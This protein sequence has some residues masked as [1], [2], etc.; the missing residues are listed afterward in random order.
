MR[1]S[2]ELANAME[3]AYARAGYVL[4]RV[5]VPEQ[6]LN[7]D[8]PL[9]SS[10]STA[11]SKKSRSTM[12]RNRYGHWSPRGMSWLIGRKRIKLT[13][14]EQHL[15]ISGD[16]PGLRLKSTL[17]RGKTTGGVLLVLEGTHQVV[18]ATATID[19]R[20]PVSLGTWTYGTTVAINSAF[21]FGEQFYG[22]A[23]AGGDPGRPS[24]PLRRC[25]CSVPAW[26]CPSAS[27]AGPSIRNTPIRAL[28]QSR[29][30]AAS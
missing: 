10:S 30:P 3:Q 5:T 17:E 15:L 20:M 9:G 14:I 23:Q 7:D 11:L 4:V 21:G 12:C 28:C 27:T 13:D 22:S 16:V 25:G 19:D 29:H 2:I 18:T 8:G 24:I 6:K 26:S 1:A